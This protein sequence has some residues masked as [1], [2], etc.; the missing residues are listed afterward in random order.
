MFARAKELSHLCML[1]LVQPVPLPLKVRTTKRQRQAP[2]ALRKDQLTHQLQ[3][4]F[5]TFKKFCTQRFFGQQA[6][7]IAQVTYEKYGDHVRQGST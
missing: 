2:Y 4:E 6:D 1:C 5:E 7:P 3:Q